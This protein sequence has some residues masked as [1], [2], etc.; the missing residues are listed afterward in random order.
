[1]GKNEDFEVVRNH[2]KSILGNLFVVSILF[3]NALKTF[4]VKIFGVEKFFR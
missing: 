1:M 3:L 4:E 2:P